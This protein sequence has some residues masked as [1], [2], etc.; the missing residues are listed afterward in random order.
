MSGSFNDLLDE[1]RQQLRVRNYSPASVASYCGHLRGF[2]GYLQEENIEDVKRVTRDLLHQYQ[3]RIVGVQTQAGKRYS[4]S[5]I[6]LKT[7]ALKRFFEYLEET[8]RILINPAEHLKEPKRGSRLPSVILT[9]EEARKILDQPDLSSMTGIRDRAILEVFYSTGIRL[10]EMTRLTLYDCD[11]QGGFLRV[12]R[13]KFARDRVVP[14]GK[15][16]ARLLK[17]YITRVRPLHTKSNRAEGCLF[18]NQSGVPL[19]KQVIQIMVRGYARKAG[20]AKKVTPH[21]FRHTFATELVKNGAE[22]TAVQKMLGHASLA[23]THLYA[24]VAAVDVKKTH[25]VHHPREKHNAVKEEIEPCIERMKG[26][27][28]HD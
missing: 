18:V 14:L 5:T 15:H 25:S 12:N 19:S 17:G 16:A 2:F 28:R 11:L 27:Y 22:I 20:I 1:F 9:D 24:R 3:A 6:A 23:V 4:V 13:G 21:V 26:R 7:R 10:E 8:N